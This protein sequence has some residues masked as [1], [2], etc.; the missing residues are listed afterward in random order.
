M[1]DS[2]KRKGEIEACLN[3][4]KFIIFHLASS[5][6]VLNPGF[7]NSLDCFP[8]ISVWKKIEE[9]IKN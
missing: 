5:Q 1:I 9:M 2:V 8:F 4:A 3:G 7:I 6:L